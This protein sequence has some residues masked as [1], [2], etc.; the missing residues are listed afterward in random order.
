MR[1]LALTFASI[2]AL[3]PFAAGTGSQPPAVVAVRVWSVTGE[4]QR[5]TGTIVAPGRVLTVEH[6]LGAGDRIEVLTAGGVRRRATVA[7]RRAD[8]DLALLRVPGATGPP[9]RVSGGAT[10][11][12][13][14]VEREGAVE[15]RPVVLRRRILARLLDQPG[16]PRRPSLELTATVS[17]GDSG[18][19]VLNHNGA[20]VGIVYAR[21][22]R[23]EGTAYAVRV[24]GADLVHCVTGPGPQGR[25]R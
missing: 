9:V 11:L 10:S 8:L 6:V 16:R 5:A 20:L 15:I 22:T 25:K 12:R 13:V 24:N 3:A 4:V 19:P 21:S 7:R 23:R 2:V 18:A 1:R 14:L 17:A